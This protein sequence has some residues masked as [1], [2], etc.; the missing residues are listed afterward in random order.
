VPD[1]GTYADARAVLG[2][3]DLLDAVPPRVRAVLE[4]G[5]RG[6]RPETPKE[7]DPAFAR[8][9]YHVV[10]SLDD[11]IAAAQ[12]A[13]QAQGLRCRVVDPVYGPVAACA[14]RLV[15][16]AERA[17][18][19]SVELLIAGGEPTVAV[20]GAGRGGRAQQLGLLLASG[21]AGRFVALVA[22]TDGND[23][24]TD[25]AG[26]LVDEGTV[27]RGEAG[28]GSVE[29]ALAATDAYP[30]LERAGDLVRTGPTDT[31]VSD[32]LLVRLLPG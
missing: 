20:R 12:S 31:N 8:A 6:E 26:A 5:D 28:G 29:Q 1:P 24:P 30:F 16:A 17:R 19:D 10:A 11:A 13:A 18:A 25:A 27:A 9:R 22:G 15:R 23:G 21:L 2:H 32:L 14:D 4:A 3:A 7:G